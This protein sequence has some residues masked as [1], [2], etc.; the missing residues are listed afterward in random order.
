MRDS[1][2][3]HW[4]IRELADVV[5]GDL[6]LGAMPPLGG[7]LEPVGPVVADS[8]HVQ[9]GDVFWA[10]DTAGDHAARYAEIAFSRDAAGAVVSRRR[11]EPWAGKFGIVVP[12]TRVALWHLAASLRRSFQGVVIAVVGSGAPRTG[13]WIRAATGEED[14]VIRGTNPRGWHPDASVRVPLELLQLDAGGRP[15][16][17]Q[18]PALE[19][20]QVEAFSH[21]CRPEIV[22]INSTRDADECHSESS[23]GPAEKNALLQCDLPGNPQFVL[24]QDTCS[25]LPLPATQGRR[26]TRVGRGPHGDLEARDVRDEQGLKFELD[27]QKVDLPQAETSDLTDVLAAFAVGRLLGKSDRWLVEQLQRLQVPPR[28][29]TQQRRNASRAAGD[30]KTAGTSSLRIAEASPDASGLRESDATLP[31]GLERFAY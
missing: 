30:E 23:R 18:L 2:L 24:C 28:R 3:N 16:V 12:D 5:G 26:V 11:L 4:S 31:P 20:A 7:D 15:C 27:G 14:A 8:H 21:L 19:R 29:A 13:A 25:P 1:L 10:L 22:V 9:S 17:L 6:R